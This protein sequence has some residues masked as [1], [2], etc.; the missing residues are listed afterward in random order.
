[1]RRA[2]WPAGASTTPRAPTASAACPS[3]RTA[4][5]PAARQRPPTSVCVSV[6]VLWAPG[7]ESLRPAS[8]GCSCC[9]PPTPLLQ[10]RGGARG[11]REGACVPPP[12]PYEASPRPS[13]TLSRRHLGRPP[14]CSLLSPST[15][16]FVSMAPTAAANQSQNRR[17]QVLGDSDLPTQP[18]PRPPRQPLKTRSPC[19]VALTTKPQRPAGDHGASVPSPGTWGCTQRVWDRPSPPVPA[20]TP[21]SPRLQALPCPPE[22]HPNFSGLPMC[23]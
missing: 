20:P 22:S 1:M 6:P 17:P 5:G 21:A 2:G 11:E 10:G 19:D 18:L 4:R 7:A 12:C 3:S 8:G 16:F 13:P 15:V 9:A 23:S 14:H